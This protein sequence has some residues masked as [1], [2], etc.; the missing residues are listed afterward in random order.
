MYHALIVDD[1]AHA[2]RGLQAGVGWD[3][4]NISVVHTAYNMRQAK[5]VF[6]TYPVSLLVC[7]IEMPLGTGLDLQA[8]VK[9]NFPK[10]E[11][12]FLTCHA[13]FSY[14]KQAVRLSSFEYLL[15][16]VDYK[17]L[18]DVI[19]RAM[20]KIKKE[21]HQPLL[22]EQFWHDLVHHILPS[23]PDK[24]A[25]HMRNHHIV[26]PESLRFLPI[27]VRIQNWHKQLTLRE[28]KIMEYALRNA[29]EEKIAKSARYAVV[30]SIRSGSLLVIL[31]VESAGY[32]SGAKL[33][34]DTF[35]RSCSDYFYCDLCCYIGE[36]VFPHQMA[37]AV[38]QLHKLD[39]NNVT[40]INQTVALRSVK[41]GKTPVNPP[42]MNEWAE[43]MKQGDKET[44]MT[45]VAQYLESCRKTGGFDAQCLH[46]FYQDFVQMVFFVL[47]LKGMP[48]HTVF[49]RSL[50]AEKPDT[51]LR[52]LKALSEWVRYIVEVAVNHIHSIPENK[53][54]VDKIKQ[55]VIENRGL[56]LSREEVAAHVY[57]N[58]DYLTRM[59]KKETGML[60][61]DYLQQQRIDFAK[62]LLLTTGRSVSDIAVSAG[63]SNLSYFS[64]LFKQATSVSPIDFRKRF[65]KK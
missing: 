37:A 46:I 49:S 1:E 31:P 33:D 59:F 11:T 52:S 2:V 43:L 61:S 54:V 12:I 19:A 10:T 6:E 28:E 38:H 40:L 13:D 42:S 22:V 41:E 8:W 63:Y 35:I 3:K 14:A 15:K 23:S 56:H 32:E 55:F 62:E 24:I 45:E 27:L 16:P 47:Q 7:D 36:S 65:H 58:P 4:L 26:Y 48:A 64:M 5:Q 20:D 51:A 9:A 30:T 34:C 21:L 53:S 17:E 25:E 50:L 39:D 29:A 57:L 18:E 44:L 60:L